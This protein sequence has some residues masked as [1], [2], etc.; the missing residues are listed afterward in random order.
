MIDN[1]LAVLVLLHIEND[2]DE[3]NFLNKVKI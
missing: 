2:V 1:K 3:V